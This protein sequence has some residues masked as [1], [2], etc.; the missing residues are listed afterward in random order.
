VPLPWRIEERLREQIQRVK[1]LHAKDVA[2]G[3]GRV[4]LPYAFAT[5]PSSERDSKVCRLH[6]SLSELANAEWV[7]PDA[8][9]LAKR[10]AKEQMSLLTFA[11]FPH[12]PA[13][14]NAAEREIRPTAV[15]RKLSYGSASEQGAATRAIL[16]SVY[17]TLK[18]RGLDAL[19]ETRKALE[20]LA[21]TGKLPPL[22][23]AASSAG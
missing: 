10:L 21:K 12:V 22:P 17:R 11:E 19:A 4:W 16:M 23:K 14:N 6:A 9:R 8:K 7:H 5:M 18:K 1:E 20:T 13:T 3:H 2:A 15:M